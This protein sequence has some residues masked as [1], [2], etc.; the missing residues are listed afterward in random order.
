MHSPENKMETE[1]EKLMQQTY[2]TN[3]VQENQ[4]MRLTGESCET[5]FAYL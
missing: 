1:M 3:Q 2:S 4:C 5:I